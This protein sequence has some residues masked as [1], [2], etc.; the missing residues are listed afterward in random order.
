MFETYIDKI[1]KKQNKKKI[2]LSDPVKNKFYENLDK[3]ARL[4]IEYI[5]QTAS[6]F[7][8]SRGLKTIQPKDIQTALY[9]LFE[10]DS[11]KP[12]KK[13]QIHSPFLKESHKHIETALEKYHSFRPQKGKRVSDMKKIDVPFPTTKVREILKKSMPSEE[14]R[15]SED[16]VIMTTALTYFLLNEYVQLILQVWNE[17][18]KN[19]TEEEKK[20]YFF[21]HR[22]MFSI[23]LKNRSFCWLYNLF[24]NIIDKLFCI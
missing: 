12:Y 7:S 2:V 20:F 21:N 9:A 1:F 17:E 8:E 24:E 3:Q 5:G 22:H 18:Y 13:D 19:P 10:L 4:L 15:I 16:V 11:K 6:A 23:C 14:T